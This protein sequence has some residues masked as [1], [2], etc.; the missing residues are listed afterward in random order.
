M[1]SLESGFSLSLFPPP[2]LHLQRFLVFAFAC[3]PP[4]FHLFC[5]SLYTTHRHATRKC[6]NEPNRPFFCPD[7]GFPTWPLA[8]HASKSAGSL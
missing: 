1:V 2:F 8:R 6:I 4:S 5:L 7:P 3:P